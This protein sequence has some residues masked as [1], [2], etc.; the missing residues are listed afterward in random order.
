MNIFK[1]IFPVFYSMLFLFLI[2]LK[3]YGKVLPERYGVSELDKNAA[4]FLIGTTEKDMDSFLVNHPVFKDKLTIS[5]LSPE[6][7][8]TDKTPE[9]YLL[10]LL[11]L[12]LGL[13]RFADPRYFRLLWEAFKS[14]F[15]GSRVA[16]DKL[17]AASFLNFLM[18]LFF[19]VSAGSYIFFLVNY[20]V[21]GGTGNISPVLLW[22]LL[23][24]GITLIYAGKYFAVR[25]S[26]W[27]FR[28]Q[29]V[30]EFY[31]YNVFLVNKVLAIALL[32]FTFLL[33]FAAP[34]LAY[35]ALLA[36]LVVMAVLLISRYF[37]SWQI[38]GSFFQYSK[39]QF[40][41]YLCASELLPLAVLMKLLV[42][43]L[44]Y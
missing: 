8:F 1:K 11:V 7:P 21:P 16:K 24:G 39:F 26:G 9:F 33:A 23:I 42:R 30:T 41:T 4:T 31:L 34:P 12:M 22:L 35:G 3:A 37:R 40:F 10:L 44:L 20:F 36:S 2:S 25:V 14:P 13:I 5:A 19:A 17:Q 29:D 32:P 38:F 43:G 18:N 28:L 27:A 6:V 15:Q